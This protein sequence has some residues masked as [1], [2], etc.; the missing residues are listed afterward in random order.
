MT[1]TRQVLLLLA[2]ALAAGGVLGMAV[3][4]PPMS[5][6]ARADAVVVLSGDGSRVPPALR[7]MDRGV[8]PTLVVA[9]E[10][11]IAAAVDLCRLPQPYEV[12]C[13]RPSPDD[14]RTEAQATARLARDRGW[15][16]VVL[17]TSKFHIARARL[18]LRRCF[19]GS[20][21]TFGRYPP[22]GLDFAR[23]Q[24]VHEWLGLVHASVLARGC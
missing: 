4:W 12:V 21:S 17:V 1:A 16:S 18:H 24:I 22:Y 15:G 3:V 6:P 9:G 10:P 7:L 20:V 5:V 8:A 11:D 13:L 23:R 14:T 19:D 2:E